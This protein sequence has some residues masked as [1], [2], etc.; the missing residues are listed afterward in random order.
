[1]VKKNTFFYYCTKQLAH[2]QQFTFLKA[3][4]VQTVYFTW[5]KWKKTW[6]QLL[7]NGEQVFFVFFNSQQSALF[8]IKDLLKIFK[9]IVNKKGCSWKVIMGHVCMESISSDTC[10]GN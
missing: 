8:H 5:K 2:F 10:V 1:M 4:N 6:F 7:S 9:M 3:A